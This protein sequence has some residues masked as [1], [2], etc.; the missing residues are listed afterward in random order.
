[1]KHLPRT[2][3]I[4]GMLHGL[5]FGALWGTFMFILYISKV[6]L[7]WWY[8]LIYFLFGVVVLLTLAYRRRHRQQASSV[9]QDGHM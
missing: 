8:G 5:G 7:R 1:M 4:G 9:R 3:L 2:A 6:P